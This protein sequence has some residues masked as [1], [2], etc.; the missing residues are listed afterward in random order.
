MR[1]GLADLPA[2]VEYP[3]RADTVR[4]GPVRDERRLMDMAAE[5][6]V[7]LVEPDPFRQFDVAPGFLAVPACGRTGGW[8]VID[9]D[10]V[11]LVL[12]AVARQL[13]GD[14]LLCLGAV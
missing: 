5:N 14:S 2:G 6:N 7:G 8:G 13:G 1:R 10:P 4:P 9:P 12:G 3:C 11:F